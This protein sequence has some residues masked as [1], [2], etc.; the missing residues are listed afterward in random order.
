MTEDRRRSPRV[1]ITR[2]V[3]GKSLANEGEV[4]VIEMSVGGM[5]IE[6][7]FEMVVG[8]RREFRVRLGDGAVVHL[9]GCVRHNRRVSGEDDPPRYVSGV[10]FID[11][12]PGGEQLPVTDLINRLR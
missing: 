7:S 12:D 9:V 3:S 8:S 1:E 11:E 6:S 2:P 10:E 5:A 4:A